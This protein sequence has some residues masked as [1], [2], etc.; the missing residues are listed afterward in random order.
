MVL[1]QKGAKRKFLKLSKCKYKNTLESN[2]KWISKFEQAEEG[3]NIY[4]LYRDLENH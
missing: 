2:L 1:D 3:T 4:L